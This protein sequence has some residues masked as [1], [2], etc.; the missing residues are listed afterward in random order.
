LP[1]TRAEIQR[2]FWRY[3]LFTFAV[4]LRIHWHALLLWLK[5]VPFFSKPEAPS[6]LVSRGHAST[7]IISKIS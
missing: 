7:T 6:E 2:T 1:A 3:P 4:M 5:R